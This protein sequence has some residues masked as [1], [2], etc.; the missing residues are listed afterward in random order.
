MWTLGYPCLT[1][2][3]TLGEVGSHCLLVVPPELL[4][5]WGGVGWA[6]PSEACVPQ[7]KGPWETVFLQA[8]VRGHR[9]EP[10]GVLL[11]L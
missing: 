3:P 10:P 2:G 4:C 6:G 9:G 5:C 1:L 7:L 8:G 11:L